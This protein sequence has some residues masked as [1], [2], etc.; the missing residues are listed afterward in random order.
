MHT[1]PN[2]YCAVVLQAPGDQAAGAEL[3]TFSAAA[4]LSSSLE[5]RHRTK[6]AAGAAKATR[7]AAPLPVYA[8]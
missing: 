5:S 6:N 1:H 7:C 2:G 4:A 8:C 3:P